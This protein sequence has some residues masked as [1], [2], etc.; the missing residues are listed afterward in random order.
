MINIQTFKDSFQKNAIYYAEHSILNKPT[1]IAY[2]KNHWYALTRISTFI[3]VSDFA[4]QKVGVSELEA[5][6]ESSLN[7]AKS[8][9][10]S[11]F[12][13]LFSSFALV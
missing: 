3:I 4:N 2:V 13:Q 11:R 6:I 9:Y 5:Q 8:N 1:V 12:K 7:Y 10:G